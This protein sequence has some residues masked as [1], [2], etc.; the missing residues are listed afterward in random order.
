MLPMI[1]AGTLA[2][3]SAMTV[4]AI[5]DHTAVRFARLS[6]SDYAFRVAG[7]L[8][9]A[10]VL[11]VSADGTD[12]DTSADPAHRGVAIERPAPPAG[13]TI[14][15]EQQVLQHVGRD[16]AAVHQRAN[17]TFVKQLTGD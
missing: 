9:G 17:F 10:A 11:A 13:G 4:T 14:M 3:L 5:S 1:G 12:F 6:L 7:G 16:Y 15:A 2:T 8:A